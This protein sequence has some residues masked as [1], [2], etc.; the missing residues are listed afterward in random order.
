[1]KI[2]IYPGSF[3]PVT[4]GHLDIIERASE[5]F[6]KLIV[7][8]M[9]NVSKFPIFTAEERM[10]LLRCVTDHL[11]NVE[12]DGYSGLLAD[13]AGKRGACTIVK[14]LRAMSDFEN[15]FSMALGQPQAEPGR[16]HSIFDDQRGIY[17]PVLLNGQG[18]RAAWR[19][20]CGVCAPENRERDITSCAK[21]W[22]KDG[23]GRRTGQ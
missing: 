21:G 23:N 20:H 2:A 8:V 4:L 6:D 14:G 1:M 16:R 3:D 18:H 5:L 11:P 13:Y 15:E 12:I 10:H 19:L 22:I 7:V 9:H 17:V